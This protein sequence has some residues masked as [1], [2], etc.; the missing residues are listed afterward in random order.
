M[1]IQQERLYSTPEVAEMLR[2]S[3]ITVKRYIQKDVVPSLRMGG[4]RRIKGSDLMK[5][6]ET[7]LPSNNSKGCELMYHGKMPRHQV[8]ATTPKASLQRVRRVGN[9]SGVN[10]L[11]SG[12]NLPILKA[13]HEDKA[14]RGKV[15]LIYIDPPFGTGQ[16]FTGIDTEHYYSDQVVNAEFLEF[17]RVRLIFLKELL[18]ETGSLYLHIDNKVG[19]YVKIILDEIF[20]DKNFRNDIT[21]IKCNPKNFDRKA[22]G[23]IKDSV[24]FYTNNSFS[25]DN[26]F[27]ADYRLPLTDDEVVR[28]FPKIDSQGMR[29]ATTPLHAKGETVNGPTGQPWK[30]LV[31]PKG[32]HWRYSPTELTRLDNLGLIEWSSKGNP[33][34]IIYAQET[35]GKKIQDVWDF[36]DPGFESAVY[37]TEKNKEL[38]R[39]IILNSSPKGGLVLDCFSGSGGTI[40]V[41]QELGRKWIGIDAN[42]K[43]IRLTERRLRQFPENLFNEPIDFSI[44]KAL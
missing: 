10:C 42:E 3:E 41:A 12:D 1:E 6:L 34:K 37:P 44:Y 5:I 29:Y 18:S 31:P 33:R 28:Q 16:I 21:R 27:W 13:L 30:N 4:L 36:K 8:I 9:P 38:L 2:V 26:S 40:L 17:L 25:E 39:Q 35:R 43:A 15:D 32:R 7:G 14:V 19:H 24:F 22:Y 11:I 20:G 23:N